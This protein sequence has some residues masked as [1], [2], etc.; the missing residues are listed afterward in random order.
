[1]RKSFTLIELLVVIAIIAILAAMLLPALSKAR[2]KARSTNCISNLKQIAMAEVM[3]AGDNSDFTPAFG[4]LVT[5]GWGWSNDAASGASPYRFLIAG[6]Y[7]GTPAMDTDT[8]GS[9]KYVR[10]F[11][12]CPSDSQYAHTS[13]S[14][15]YLYLAPH[16]ANMKA[17][18]K[19]NNKLSC[20]TWRIDGVGSPDNP[21]Y[22]DCSLWTGNT[23]VN[24]DGSANIACLGGHVRTIKV[25]TSEAAW[26]FI[27][28]TLFDVANR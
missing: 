1:M 16:S 2:E 28:K 15:L 9:D 17:A 25:Q 3:Y 26:T 27:T 19:F 18:D 11:F 21:I 5:S 8:A 13:S 14:Y 23:R 20:A 22:H 6:G 4:N 10:Q 24:H 12:K 7:L